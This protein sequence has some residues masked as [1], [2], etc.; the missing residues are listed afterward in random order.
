MNCVR[1]AGS[2]CAPTSGRIR[3]CCLALALA[4]G[5]VSCRPD[6]V[7]PTRVAEGTPI[8]LVSID[9]L[10]AD[11]LPDYGYAGVKTPA[12]SRLAA[13]G[14]VFERA[15]AHT[16][17]TLPSH[18]T[19]FTGLLPADHEVRD[20]AG[21]RLDTARVQSGGIPFLPHQLQALG[22]RTCGA[23]SAFVL[24]RATGMATGFEVYDDG[25]EFHSRRG[26]GELQREGRQTLA[27]AERCLD[28]AGGKPLFLFLHLYEPHAPYLPPEPFASVYAN[29]YDGEIAAADQVVGE[30][31]AGLERRGLYDRALVVLLSD[32]GEGLGDHGEA[33]HGVLL[34]VESIHVPLLLKLPGRALAGK[35]V[36]LPAGLADVAP[37]L[38]RLLGRPQS[39]RQHG[40]SLLS[41]LEPGAAERRVYSE[42]FYPRLHF[43][44]SDL[45]SLIDGRTHLISGPAPELY[46]LVADPRERTNV[47]SAQRRLFAEFRRELE[48]Y[49][50]EL[51][52]PSAVD[53]E[54]RRAM[55]SLGYLGSAAETSG[56]LPD[57]KL[58]LHAIA[59]LQEGTRLFSRGDLQGAVAALQKV[60]AASPQ[61]ADGWEYL[62]NAL[63]KL[64][65]GREAEAA[66]REAM[67]A[68]RGSGTVAASYAA[69]LLE[70]GRID[71]AESHARLAIATYPSMAHRLLARIALAKKDFVAAEAEARQALASPGD[72]IG[73]RIVLADV[74]RR[75][76]RL[77]EGLATLRDA[78]LDYERRQAPDPEL[79]A[80]LSLLEGQIL[81]DLGDA[82]GAEAAF[83]REIALFPRE[84]S[85]RSHLALLYALMG[86]EQEAQRTLLEMIEANGGPA[87]WAEAVRALRVLGHSGEAAKLLARA[88]QTFPQS[89]A[90][91]ALR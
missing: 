7:A 41:L 5:A 4:L 28:G 71:E 49:R 42:T 27:A 48:G 51:V 15:Y 62:A 77:E 90:L 11:H 60:T 29:K 65:R 59:D 24:Q 54:T 61:M 30:L 34:N 79:I 72:P 76:A 19:L 3:C 83:K 26:L 55:A 88:R 8:V 13:D 1:T 56:P 87:G 9:T 53:E 45:A 78:R 91:A 36:A 68:S 50:R 69:L 86:R 35:R 82:A 12:I 43:G 89:E 84:P 17:L 33:E 58:H 63:A 74:L 64:G 81:A 70:A 25:I 75:Q 73:A 21:Y 39:E 31:L 6:S 46:D 57:P 47:V 80:G 38:L 23:V 32:H 85:P 2:A 52:P 20:N 40:V 14:V 67:R 22:Y 66:Y 18:L 16:P 44:W 37:T 10:R